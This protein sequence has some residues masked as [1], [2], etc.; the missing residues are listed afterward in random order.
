MGWPAGSQGAARGHWL[1]A[2]AVLEAE[3]GLRLGGGENW[4][5]NRGS[6]NIGGVMLS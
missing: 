2:V 1:L 5:R 4:N 6:S 3:G